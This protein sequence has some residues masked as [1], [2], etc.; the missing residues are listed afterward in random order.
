MAQLGQASGGWTESSSALRVEHAGIFNATGV[1]TEDAFTQTNPPIVTTAGTIS[2]KVDTTKLGILSGSVAFTRPDDAD[3]NSH[4]G[5]FS[6]AATANV[7]P[8]GIYVN[9]ALGNAFENTPAVASG[10]GTYMSGMGTYANQLYETQVLTGGTAGND[11]TAYI[12]GQ[13]LYASRNG[14]L[15]NAVPGD[16]AGADTALQLYEGAVA[17]ATVIGLVKMSPDA[18]QNELLYDQRI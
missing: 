7:I 2:D 5:P 16:Y 14:Y 3:G 18:V 15:T 13:R 6:P 10:K 12:P 4:G 9:D 1:L 11:L 17:V 8:L